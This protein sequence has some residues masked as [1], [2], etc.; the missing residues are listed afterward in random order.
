[1][2]RNISIDVLFPNGEYKKKRVGKI[3]T[4]TLF[5]GST[6]LS[7]KKNKFTSDDLLESIIKERHK[8]LKSIIDQYNKCCRLIKDVNSNSGQCMTFVA[9]ISVPEC[10]TYSSI[11]A[12]E[13]ISDNLRRNYLDTTI[14][15]NF[16]IFINWEDIEFKKE[17]AKIKKENNKKDDKK[18]DEK[19]D[20]KR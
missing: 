10:S 11:D 8:K 20:E 1:M 4:D 5:D 14:I 17:L 2:N 16:T 9:P 6:P 12:L 18:D 7:S 13:Y 15:N 19:D 3:D